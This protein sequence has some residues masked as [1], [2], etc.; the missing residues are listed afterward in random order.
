MEAHMRLPIHQI[1][2]FTEKPFLGNPAAVMPLDEWLSDELMQSIAM[3]NQ[4]SETAFFV[5]EGD[6][7]R[8]RWFTPANEVDLCGHA[9]LASAW[10]ILN[11]LQPDWQAVQF[12]SMS[13]P[14]HVAKDGDW[15]IMD[16]PRRPGEPTPQHIPALAKVLGITPTEVLL[17]R[18]LVAVLASEGQ[19]RA[20]KPDL[21]AMTHL[22]GYGV[23]A[24]AK[25]ES[26]DF[27][28]RCFFPA[29]GIPEDPVTG[30]AHSTLIPYWSARLKKDCLEAMQLSARGGFL[31]CKDL[32]DRVHI[33]GKAVKVMEGAMIL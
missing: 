9:T 22:P 12:Q 10:L 4:L 3:E 7:Y 14:L 15:L 1:D 31:R 30:S 33:A 8:I 29:D 5:A 28:S 18:D 21:M 2:A 26:V 11:Q 23:L 20:L 24:T 19:V 13:G 27:V 16:F 32:S 17:S 25:G 6:G